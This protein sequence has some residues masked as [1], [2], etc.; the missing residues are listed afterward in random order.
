VAEREEESG[1][2]GMAGEGGDYGHREGEESEDDWFEG[3]DQVVE[4]IYCAG[5]GAGG[6]G[7]CEVEAVGEEFAMGGGDECR[8]MDNLGFDLGESEDESFDES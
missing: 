1:S 8:A 2:G 3:S 6:L 4:S 7:L 5:G